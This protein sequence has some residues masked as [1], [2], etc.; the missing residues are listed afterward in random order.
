[1]LLKVLTEKAQFMCNPFAKSKKV[2]FLD[3]R[4]KTYN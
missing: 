4:S 3:F 1:M 2:V